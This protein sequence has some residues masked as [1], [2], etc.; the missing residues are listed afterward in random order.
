MVKVKELSKSKVSLKDYIEINGHRYIVDGIKVVFEPSKK[1][2]HTALWLS[3]KLNKKIEILPRI[4][5]PKNI[6]TSDYLINNEYWVIDFKP[7]NS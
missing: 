6:K 1:E 3:R 5:L 4:A 7:S 2:L